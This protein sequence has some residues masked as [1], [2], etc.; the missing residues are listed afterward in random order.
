MKVVITNAG[1]D[2]GVVVNRSLQRAGHTVAGSGNGRTACWP[3]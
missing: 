2:L 1:S 3:S